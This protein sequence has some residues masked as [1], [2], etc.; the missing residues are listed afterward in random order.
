MQVRSAAR[1]GTPIDAGVDHRLRGLRDAL[2]CA[3]DAGALHR[4]GAGSRCAP[5][6]ASR[7]NAVSM[8]EGPPTASLFAVLKMFP[9][10]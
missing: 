7:L 3:S 5:L 10:T 6:G 4:A 8:E 2:A 1:G 9:A